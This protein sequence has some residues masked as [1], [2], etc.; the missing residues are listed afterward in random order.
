MSVSCACDAVLSA[1]ESESTTVHSALPV[2]LSPRPFSLLPPPSSRSLHQRRPT[3]SSAPAP[4]RNSRRAAFGG[5]LTDPSPD[6]AQPPPSQPP[7][8]R[9]HKGK[10]KATQQRASSVASNGV[11]GGGGTGGQLVVKKEVV[12][13]LPV[14]PVV[15]AVD[16][17]CFICAETVDPEQARYWALGECGH[18]TCHTCSIRL[19]ALCTSPPASFSTSGTAS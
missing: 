15:D 13:V 3:M 11:A 8:R 2:I 7:V 10:G 14:L 19:R 16:D 1:T 17:M 4:P 12:E 6:P 5:A 9:D 18:R